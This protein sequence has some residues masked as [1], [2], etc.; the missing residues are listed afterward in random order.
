MNATPAGLRTV[1]WDLPH[2]LAVVGK[3]RHMANEILTTW[4]FGDQADDVILVVGELL[5]NA[6]SHGA[7]PIRLSLWATES[8]LCVR[9]TD[10]GTGTPRALDLG[11]DAV[12]GRGL[13]IVAALADD[14]G[15]IPLPNGPGKTIWA[16]WRALPARPREAR[17]TSETTHS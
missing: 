13:P 3:A 10:H 16:R 4:G 5:G 17:S 1:G 12:H 2:D 7:P 9:V 14:H 15:V 8:H 11:L 6:I